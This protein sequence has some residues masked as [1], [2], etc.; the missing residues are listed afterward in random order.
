M[1]GTVS[2]ITGSSVEGIR[3]A[4]PASLSEIKKEMKEVKEHLERNIMMTYG[5]KNSKHR[6]DSE[7]RFQVGGHHPQYDGADAVNYH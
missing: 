3:R 6:S 1:T 2:T 7:R 4:F 5:S